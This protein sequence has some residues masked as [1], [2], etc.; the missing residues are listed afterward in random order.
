MGQEQILYQLKAVNHYFYYLNWSEKK[1][2]PKQVWEIL[3][4]RI[5]SQYKS[6]ILDIRI[7]SL[8]RLD[9]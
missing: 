9:V 6:L 1:K 5:Y 3:L 4:P 2:S 8:I 7:R